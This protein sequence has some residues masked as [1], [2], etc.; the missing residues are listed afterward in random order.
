M[1]WRSAGLNPHPAHE[2]NAGSPDSVLASFLLYEC[3]LGVQYPAV[4]RRTILDGA[5]EFPNQILLLPEEI[6]SAKQLSSRR[7]KLTLQVWWGKT[8]AMQQRP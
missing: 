8:I 2:S 1:I 5:V 3:L 6:R 4:Y 7:T